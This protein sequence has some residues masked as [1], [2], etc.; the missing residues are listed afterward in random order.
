MRD[1]QICAAVVFANVLAFYLFK[2]RS[3]NLEVLKL[4]IFKIW[5]EAEFKEF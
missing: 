2:I 3:V 4:I 5:P 1:C